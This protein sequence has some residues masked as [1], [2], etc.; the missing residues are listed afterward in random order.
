MRN[1][2][3]QMKTIR[4]TTKSDIFLALTDKHRQLDMDLHIWKWKNEPRAILIEKI[5]DNEILGMH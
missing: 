5:I 1:F 3:H 2:N 4:F